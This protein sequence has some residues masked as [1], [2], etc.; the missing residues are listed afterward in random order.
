MAINTLGAHVGDIRC[1]IP[2]IHKLPGIPEMNLR[3]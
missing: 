2:H 1:L 3:R